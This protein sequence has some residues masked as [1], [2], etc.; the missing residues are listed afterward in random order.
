[1]KAAT[2]DS[3]LKAV[4][5]EAIRQLRADPVAIHTSLFTMIT[6]WSA[7]QDAEPNTDANALP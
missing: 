5:N 3:F 7:L 6:I 4:L 2:T 1:M